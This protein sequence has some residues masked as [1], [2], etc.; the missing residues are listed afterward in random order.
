MINGKDDASVLVFPSAARA[1]SR[2]ELK[3]VEAAQAN[4][5]ADK[6]EGARPEAAVAEVPA[7]LH[8]ITLADGSAMS[9]LVAASEP[10]CRPPRQGGQAA[11]Q[12]GA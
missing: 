2:A 11:G 8:Q 4:V 7:A 1:F 9:V 10:V 5:R 6:G 3:A 12:V